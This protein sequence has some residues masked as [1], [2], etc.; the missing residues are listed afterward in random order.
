MSNGGADASDGGGFLQ[1]AAN[2]LMPDT[3]TKLGE[4]KKNALVT[5]ALKQDLIDK[6]NQRSAMSHIIGGRDPNSPDQSINWSPDS[7]PTGKYQMQDGDG[8]WQTY[9]LFGPKGASPSQADTT[10]ENE[11]DDT[12]TNP[13]GTPGVDNRSLFGPK[14]PPQP[15]SLF[16]DLPQAVKDMQSPDQQAQDYKQS[17]ANYLRQSAPDQFIGSA[18]QQ[19][20]MADRMK[21]F[22]SAA[23]VGG[24]F[25][26]NDM[27][28][29]AIDPSLKLYGDV[30]KSRLAP[31]EQQK[32]L[33]AYN[34]IPDGDPRRAQMLPFIQKLQGIET[35]KN[36]I[37]ETQASTAEK[38]AQTGLA[39]QRKDLL[40]N[41]G[42]DDDT[43]E[44]IYKTYATTGDLA[45]AI[46]P[47][48]RGA[49]A[50]TVISTVRNY[51]TKRM[52]DD[53]LS[54]SEIAARK[55]NLG[56]QA[57]AQ[58][59]AAKRGANVDMG[60][61]ELDTF[62]DQAL[63]ALNDVNNGNFKPWNQI[64]NLTADQI[65][66]PALAAYKTALQG[67]KGAYASVI[68]RG[69][70]PSVDAMH[71]A[72]ELL[73]SAQGP[74]AVK[75]II[76]QMKNEASGVKSSSTQVQNNINA[77]AAGK[78]PAPNQGA[79]PPVAP[80]IGQRRPNTV[81]MTPKG[82]LNWTGTGWVSP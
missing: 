10:A 71:K 8:N 79:M 80:P 20:L 40:S 81:Y 60:A 67:V 29:I 7:A 82:P 5:Q 4:M 33:D 53:D 39:N 15:A 49:N 58:T 75:A 23:G 70:V 3:M 34:A 13:S 54:P 17:Q 78:E 73:S 57:A 9:S 69:G 44:N 72:D 76:A 48:P 31:T 38:T 43:L 50:Q 66:D 35:D 56:A 2:L 59:T 25:D 61:I 24:G 19:A 74:G 51:I 46:G 63:N 6:N 37:A 55:I 52:N 18:V 22:Q 62:A 42:F 32:L 21:N 26:Q 28:L 14:A 68:S 64:A 16:S 36:K 47:M 12:D 65:S 30:L 1:G 11:I 41:S 27:K 45:K 77:R